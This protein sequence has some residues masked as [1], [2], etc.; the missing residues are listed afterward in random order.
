MYVVEKVKN[1]EK[2]RNRPLSWF[3]LW[4]I[5]LFSY[6]SFQI[7][8]KAKTKFVLSLFR[9][10]AIHLP[11]L[12]PM[13]LPSE[14]KEDFELSSFKTSITIVYDTVSNF[15]LLFG[16]FVF[17]YTKSASFLARGSE[18]KNKWREVNCAKICPKA[19]LNGFDG[20]IDFVLTD[21][22]ESIWGL[23]DGRFVVTVVLWRRLSIFRSRVKVCNFWD[24]SLRLLCAEKKKVSDYFVWHLCIIS[25]NW[26]Q[27]PFSFSLVVKNSD[28]K[29]VMLS[30][31]RT[32]I[33]SS[34]ALLHVIFGDKFDCVGSTDNT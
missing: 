15:K 13:I 4:C 19:G 24:S 6:P 10:T 9:S 31:S 33:P 2:R 8:G 25:R 32:S 21:R 28:I 16:Y 11:S 23:M 34:M 20:K 3:Y 27:L 7:N 29:A 12:Q 22:K 14:K 5:S 26:S 1:L 18:L 17:W 30:T